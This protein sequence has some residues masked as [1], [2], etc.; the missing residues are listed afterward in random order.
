MD[1]IQD[2]NDLMGNGDGIKLIQGSEQDQTSSTQTTSQNFIT[3]TLTGNFL[4]LPGTDSTG[5]S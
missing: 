4:F 1:E 2:N 5:K 3:P